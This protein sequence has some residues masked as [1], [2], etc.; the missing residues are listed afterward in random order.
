MPES[1]LLGR[2]KLPDHAAVELEFLAFLVEQ[3]V[4]D[5]AHAGVWQKVRTLFLQRHA[6]RWLPK[7]GRKL[8]QADDP[9]WAA[10][11]LLLTAVTTE[12][13]PKRMLGALASSKIGLPH[14]N[15]LEECSLCGFCTQVCPTRALS[16]REDALT[17]NLI[18]QPDL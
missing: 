18:L 13:I 16:V 4:V 7:V 12:P 11:G 14:I 15:T 17:T 10:I 8:A 2:V 6:G 3:E 9:G 1:R 5:K